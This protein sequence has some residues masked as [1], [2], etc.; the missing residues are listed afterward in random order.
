MYSYSQVQMKLTRPFC[1][2]SYLYMS[3]VHIQTV[4]EL[5]FSEMVLMAFKMHSQ[6][7][8]HTSF[9]SN[10]ERYLVG[11]MFQLAMLVLLFTL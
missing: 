11:D 10:T 3:V 1:D 5:A 7:W 9:F 2:Y 4:T 8:M 6:F